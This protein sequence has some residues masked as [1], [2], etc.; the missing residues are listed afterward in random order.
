[1]PVTKSRNG[2]HEM[3]SM[4]PSN[5]TRF[6]FGDDEPAATSSDNEYLQMNTTD[7]KF[8]ILVRREDYPG[9]SVSLLN[10]SLEILLTA[11]RNL[12]L[13]MQVLTFLPLPLKPMAG[14]AHLLLTA[15][16]SLSRAIV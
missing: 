12:P 3:L 6:L 5:T 15:I 13:P 14:R 4:D 8:P 11:R 16:L 10:P 2:M 1:M 7:D 9:G